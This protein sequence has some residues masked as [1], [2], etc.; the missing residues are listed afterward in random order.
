MEAYSFEMPEHSGTH[1]DAPV[2]FSKNGLRI[3]EIPLSNHLVPGVVIDCT[4]QA[5]KDPDYL[6]SLEDVQKFEKEYGQIPQ[7]A[8]VLM[9][10]GWEQYWGDP[11][12]FLGIEKDQAAEASGGIGLGV[13]KHYPAMNATAVDWLVRNRD[14][15]GIGVDTISPDNIRSPTFP[16]HRR[17]CEDNRIIIE[18]VR[19]G[20]FPK[21]IRNGFLLETLPMRI[22][23][24]TGGPTRVLGLLPSGANLPWNGIDSMIINILI[25][26]I[27][28]QFF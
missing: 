24:G 27:C 20:L 18:N 2:H 9:R 23:H 28:S 12:K 4:E 21:N 16:V 10:T 1:M 15:K 5:S 11:D 6:M 17:L 26:I 3:D 19:F 25:G 14:I 8:V 7:G 22:K 13:K